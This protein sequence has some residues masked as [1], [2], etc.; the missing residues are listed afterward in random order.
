MSGE[1]LT[2]P[3]SSNGQDMDPAIHGQTRLSIGRS[4]ESDESGRG[5]LTQVPSERPEA[6]RSVN[7][8]RAIKQEW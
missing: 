8:A 4:G 1:I 5:R 6:W 7:L 3:G 2:E